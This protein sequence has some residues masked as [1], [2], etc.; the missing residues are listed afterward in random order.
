MHTHKYTR[1]HTHI[2]HTHTHTH[3]RITPGLAYIFI[4][5]MRIAR[6]VSLA[7]IA[8]TNLE[9]LLICLGFRA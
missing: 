6:V 2:T 3:T 8:V 5:A 1:A 4:L 7:S 9:P